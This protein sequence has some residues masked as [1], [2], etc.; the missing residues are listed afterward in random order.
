M[1]NFSYKNSRSLNGQPWLWLKQ[2]SKVEQKSN[3]LLRYRVKNRMHDMG[4]QLI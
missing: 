4:A 3:K 1:L 2:A